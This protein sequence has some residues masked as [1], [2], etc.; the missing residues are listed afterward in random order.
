M[1][2][3]ERVRVST[4]LT[5]EE[6]RALRLLAAERDQLV[7]E[8]LR[9]LIL[10]ELDRCPQGVGPVSEDLHPAPGYPGMSVTRTGVVYGPRGHELKR[11][12][13]FRDQ[14]VVSCSRG[15]P[16]GGNKV[17]VA[18]LLCAA[19]HGPRPSPDHWAKNLGRSPWGLSP[20]NVAWVLKRS[21]R[22]TE[23]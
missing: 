7:A 2:D 11:V 12:L 10:K 4:Y 3:T 22:Q 14:L 15:T 5:A 23:E 6:R 21:A 13:N 20:E 16:T 19:F 1:E 17:S 9:R 8:V 18:E